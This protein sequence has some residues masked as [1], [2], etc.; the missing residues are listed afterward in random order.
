MSGFEPQVPGDNITYTATT[1]AAVLNIIS[2]PNG[3]IERTGTGAST[4]VFPSTTDIMN[5]QFDSA[6]AGTSDFDDESFMLSVTNNRDNTITQ[7]MGAGQT[8][9]PSNF[10]GS[11]SVDS[12]TAGGTGYSAGATT[13]TGDT[14]GAV[15]GVTITE[16]GGVVDGVTIDSV[17]SGSPQA[18]ETFSIVGGDG[19]A[20]FTIFIA[21]TILSGQARLYEFVVNDGTVPTMSVIIRSANSAE[22]T[23]INLASGN[24]L[25]GQADGQAA[26]VTMSSEGSIDATGAFTLG[27]TIAGATTF[28]N[29]GTAISVPTGTISGAT[30]TDG[31]ASLNAGTLTGLVTPTAGSDATNKDYVDNLLNGLKWKNPVRALSDSNVAITG[32]PSPVDGVTMVTGDRIMLT[33]QTTASENGIWVVD[34]AGA[35][36]RPADFATGD[37]ASAAAAFV[38]EGST[39][40]DTAWVCTTDPPNDIVDTDNLA[41]VQFAGSGI[42]ISSINN[43]SISSK[44]N[45]TNK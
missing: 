10:A 45:S 3:Q 13:A 43:S 14:S 41:F 42:G 31:T 2:K 38:E 24:I 4:D 37:S 1:T 29:A 26:G 22:V 25:V 28:S 9:I 34:T 36:T 11:Y 17:N 7:R 6:A 23:G 12:I 44:R 21:D 27:S 15:F 18:G 8:L 16:T 5:S 32:D 40:A 20:D 19:A 33:G 30:I 39:Y 35:W